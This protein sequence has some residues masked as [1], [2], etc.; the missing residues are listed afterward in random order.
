LH[1]SL[2]KGI[3]DNDGF[4]DRLCFH[5]NHGCITI[6]I[7]TRAADVGRGRQRYH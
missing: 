6:S 4:K 7:K 1:Y 2:E 5:L 3:S